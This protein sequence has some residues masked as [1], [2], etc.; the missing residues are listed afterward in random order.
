MIAAAL[1]L[2][3]IPVAMIALQPDLGTAILITLAGATVVFLC[4]IGVAYIIS[5]VGAALI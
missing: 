1:G 5:A 2:T 3:L 4:G